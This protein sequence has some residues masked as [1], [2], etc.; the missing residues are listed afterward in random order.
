MPLLAAFIGSLF[1]STVAFLALFI[2]KRIA[3]VAA[4]LLFTISMT[5]TFMTA[6]NAAASALV[7]A[8]PSEIAIAASWV[9][10]SNA[11]ACL[12][13]WVTANLLTWAWSWNTRILQ[14]KLF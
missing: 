10:P 6:V 12:A 9:V 7:T 14:L 3:I 4:V 13:A 11:S 8:M 2:T 1:T 5:A